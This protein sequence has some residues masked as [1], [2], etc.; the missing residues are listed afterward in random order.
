MVLACRPDIV[1][2][3]ADVQAGEGISA[4]RQNRAVDRTLTFLKDLQPF[5]GEQV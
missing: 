2:L 3:P 1:A 4:K 5:I